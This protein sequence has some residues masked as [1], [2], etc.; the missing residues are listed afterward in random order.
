MDGVLAPGPS[1]VLGAEEKRRVLEAL[2]GSVGAPVT[3][4]NLCGSISQRSRDSRARGHRSSSRQQRP[5]AG[6][7]AG[8]GCLLGAQGTQAHPVGHESSGVPMGQVCSGRACSSSS[9]SFL[10]SCFSISN[11]HLQHQ[12]PFSKSPSPLPFALCPK[13]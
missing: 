2:E 6:D 3:L 1:C 5:G 7:L 9:F 11:N 12:G 10:R 4:Q 8:T 13:N